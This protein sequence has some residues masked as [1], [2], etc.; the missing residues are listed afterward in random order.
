MINLLYADAAKILTPKYY[1]QRQFK[2]LT[3]I[4]NKA[5][6]IAITHKKFINKVNEYADFISP[7]L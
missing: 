2:N 3:N 1:Y 7:K 5:D 4:E 6:Y